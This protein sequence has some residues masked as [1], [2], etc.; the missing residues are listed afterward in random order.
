MI[1]RLRFI[2]VLSLLF[3][4]GALQY[5]TPFFKDESTDE[6]STSQ[7]KFKIDVSYESVQANQPPVYIND[8]QQV[9]QG[10]FFLQKQ[11]QQGYLLSPLLDTR[12]DMNIT[13]LIARAKVTQTFT[14]I[15][16]E[17]VNGIY[18][19][20]LPENAAVDHLEMLIGERRIVGQIHPKQKAKAI[21]EQAKREGKKASLLVQQRPNLF[22]NSVANIGPGESIKVTIEYQQAVA[23]ENNTFSLRF[24]TTVTPRYLPKLNMNAGA[25]EIADSGWGMTQPVYKD[26]QST[27]IQE[28]PEPMHKVAMHIAL[29]TGFSVQNIQSELHPIHQLEKQAGVY[30][31][32]LQQDM[33]ANQDFVLSWQPE[34][35]QE[36][37][38][39][40][41]VERHQDAF[42]GMVMLMPPDVDSQTLSLAREVIFVIDTS[43]SMSGDAMIQA[44]QALIYAIQELPENDT[45]NLVEFDSTARKMWSS[46]KV[47]NTRVKSEAIDYIANLQADGGTEMLSAL[48][49]ALGQ[50]SSGS[51]GNETESR[52]RQVIFITD[53]SVGNEVSLFDYIQHNLQQS[54]LFTVGIGSA[55]NS[56][57]MGEAARMGKGTFTYIGSTDSVQQ[58]MQGLFTKLT[59]PILTDL[60]MN[61]SEDVEVYPRNLPDL[62]KGEPI[63]LSYR[64]NHGVDNLSVTGTLKDQYWQQSLSLQNGG[65]ER[66]LNVLWARRKIAQL[67]RDKRLDQDYDEMNKQIEEVAMTHHIVSEMTSLVAVDVTPSAQASSKDAQLKSHLP[68]GQKHAIGSLPQTAT[69]AQLQWMLA[70]LLMG[71]GLC[72]VI[73]TKR[74]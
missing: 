35:N 9:E 59:H 21:F 67:G 38:A 18:V 39:A 10:S 63:M 56:F 15:S 6:R 72:T 47:A 31:I 74:H 34:P 20:P 23:Y 42:Y 50:Q 13:G 26:G 55:P 57:F 40:H 3:I 17:W 28:E 29:N 11:G 71:M 49:L 22:K 37:K 7:S 43:G 51:S 52:I 8:Y 60:V 73:F 32:S 2:I 1:K 5:A 19:F 4:L 53:G 25:Q 41:F 14:N 30:E 65:S 36:P 69:P 48:Q 61:F 66:G 62:Y 27:L 46:P 33:I 45:F 68:K 70:L 16:D 54:R 44:K 24:P 12:V 64:A 58:Q